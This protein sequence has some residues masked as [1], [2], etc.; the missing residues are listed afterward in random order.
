M[1]FRFGQEGPKHVNPDRVKFD[2]EDS[3]VSE[4]ITENPPEQIIQEAWS[5]QVAI[6]P[7]YR[8]LFSRAEGTVKKLKLALLSSLALTAAL[9]IGEESRSGNE[10]AGGTLEKA[11]GETNSETLLKNTQEEVCALMDGDFMQRFTTLDE[12]G[13]E[14]FNAGAF[15]VPFAVS[16]TESC[17]TKVDVEIHIPYHFAR[18][19]KEIVAKNPEARQ[20]MIE[21]LAK[22]IQEQVSNQ[23]VIRGVA[24]VT[25][26]TLVWNKEHN[27]VYQGKPQVDLGALDV[28]DLTLTGL[29]SAEAERDNY[30]GVM[31]APQGPDSLT[32]PN[33][34]NIDLAG[35]R[36]DELMPLLLPALERAGISSG[37]IENIKS[38]S[39]EKD[40]IEADVEKLAQMS[41]DI[42]GETLTSSSNNYEAAFQLVKEYNHDNPT[43]VEA[44]E[45]NPEYK[46]TMESLFD[47]NRG[48]NVELV[49]SVQNEKETV[50]PIAVLLPLLLLLLGSASLSRT[51]G[52]TR[53]INHRSRV[54]ERAVPDTVTREQIGVYSA[55]RRLF[56]EVTPKELDQQRSFDDVYE[57]VS[58]PYQERQ[59]MVDHLLQE[60]VFPS[61]DEATRE[62]YIDYE[63]LVNRNRQYLR[64]DT[65]NDGIVKGGYDT[66]PEAERKITEDLIEMWERHDAHLYPMPGI[67]TKTVLNYRHSEQVV[68]W[69]KLLAPLFVSLMKESSTTEEF[70]ESLLRM[71]NET[72]EEGFKDRN[73]F[74]K[75]T[76]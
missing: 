2:Q 11:M 72:R 32:G 25:D 21:R 4:T 63:A 24:G 44:L 52:G 18:T 27:A 53:T 16:V 50:Y 36:R 13:D 74:V 61:L 9:N 10:S 45:K 20:E 6:P 56:S 3:E 5:E 42:L 48:V 28:S 30:S 54:L 47:A 22:L 46:T 68:G 41:R 43:V 71:I 60:E 17:K 73:T 38:V 51:P 59:V 35:K 12:H 49:A 75:S 34:A 70:R 76:I 23:L 31:S 19:F 39:F 1:K 40:L 33:S 58:V 26:T 64:S 66:T 62:P 8:L 67:D 15:V 37:A 55:K 57:Q 29:A 69:A 65:R 7:Q 14:G